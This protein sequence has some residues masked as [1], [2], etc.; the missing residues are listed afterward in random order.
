MFVDAYEGKEQQRIQKL[1]QKRDKKEAPEAYRLRAGTKAGNFPGEKPPKA[2]EYVLFP[3]EW[4][5]QWKWYLEHPS[6]EKP[7]KINLQKLL[8]SHGKLQFS[9]VPSNSG[10]SESQDECPAS[11]P[12]SHTKYKSRSKS[13]STL[14]DKGPGQKLE[15]IENHANTCKVSSPMNES[16]SAVDSSS[17]SS[18]SFVSTSSSLA[19]TPSPV[20]LDPTTFSLPEGMAAIIGVKDWEYLAKKYQVVP[21][22]F[23]DGIRVHFTQREA[24]KGLKSWASINARPE[25]GYCFSCIKNRLERESIEEL[26]YT[27]GL[28]WCYFGAG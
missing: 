7:G 17:I 11:T 6:V 28:S 24:G 27:S 21:K 2:G 15:V 9:P 5:V 10:Y 8:C 1:R 26:H 3:L 20:K 13:K 12:A 14:I 19:Q 22:E 16:L 25:P 18:S 4:Q 23:S